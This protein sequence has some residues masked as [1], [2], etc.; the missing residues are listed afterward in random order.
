MIRTLDARRLGVDAVVAALER[1]PETVAPE[2]HRTVDAILAAVRAR[3]DAA[4]CEYTA[5]LDGFKA[6]GAADL[7]LRAADFAAAEH[8]AAPEVRAALE[9]A[10]DRIERYHAA[11]MPKSWRITDEHGSV[12]G[13]E[14]RPLDRVGV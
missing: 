4:L 10:A 11:A 13:Q 14:I 3:G 8:A 5:Q 9:Y 7:A 6:A 1:S 12:L 2:I